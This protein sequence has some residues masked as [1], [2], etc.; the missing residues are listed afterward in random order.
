M[1]RSSAPEAPFSS[2]SRENNVIKL[3]TSP[4]D[5]VLVIFGAGHLGWLRQDFAA[6]PTLRLRK[7]QDFVPA[8]TVGSERR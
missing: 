3:M 5:R 6:D 4:E 8:A 1:H 7:L 2:H